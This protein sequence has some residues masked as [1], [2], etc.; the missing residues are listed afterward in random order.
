M[1]SQRLHVCRRESLCGSECISGSSMSRLNICPWIEEDFFSL[2][3]CRLWNLD[4]IFEPCGIY[5]FFSSMFIRSV[6]TTMATWL[7]NT[8]ARGTAAAAATAPPY[9]FLWLLNCCRRLPRPCYSRYW[10]FL[11]AFH[12]FHSWLQIII[13]GFFMDVLSQYT[14][15]VGFVHEKQQALKLQETKRNIK[16]PTSLSTTIVIWTKWKPENFGM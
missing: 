14:V 16:R 11:A 3:I 7:L 5:F 10:R 12:P 1:V 8:S 4:E 9:M 2:R 13:K 15:Q 6:S